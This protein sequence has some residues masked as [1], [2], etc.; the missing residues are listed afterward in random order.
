ME[1]K[2]MNLLESYKKLVSGRVAP[3]PHNYEEV[4]VGF[5]VDDASM[6]A[7]YGR[8]EYTALEAKIGHSGGQLPFSEDEFLK[9]IRTLV[10]S[11]ILWVRNEKTIV[12][13]TDPISV[14][15]F[16]SVILMNIGNA[17][18]PTLG[19]RL[20][21]AIQ[22]PEDVKKGG[23]SK[24]EGLSTLDINEM[25]R[26]S[27]YLASIDGYS[28]S[29]GYLRDKSGVFDFMSMQFVDGYIMHHNAD[30]HPVYALLASV[31]KPHII[32]SALSPLVR[33]GSEDFLGGLLWEVTAV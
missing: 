30:S 19:L 12:V 20:I 14:P 13:P 1:N 24:K 9:Y 21:P 26:I 16:L 31:M 8:T 22:A 27:S 29:K 6:L 5:E 11:R 25:R 17:D 15:A 32:T 3:A 10:I 7:Q 4:T 2:T 28:F 23:D 33:Y 18:E